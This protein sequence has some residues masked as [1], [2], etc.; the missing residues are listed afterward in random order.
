LIM[1]SQPGGM[2]WNGMDLMIKIDR[3]QLDYILQDC[4]QG[5]R[6]E[7]LKCYT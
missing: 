3:S 6:L 5:I 7:M 2:K 4:N 1:I